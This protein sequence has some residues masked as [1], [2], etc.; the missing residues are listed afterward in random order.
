[1]KDSFN[2]LKKVLK[3]NKKCYIMEND[4]RDFK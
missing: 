4:G 1:M 3:N 2:K